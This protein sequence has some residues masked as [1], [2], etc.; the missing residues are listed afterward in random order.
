[1]ITAQVPWCQC[2][3]MCLRIPFFFLP[4]E[5]GATS[6][7]VYSKQT[8]CQRPFWVSR[9]VH[10]SS[11]GNPWGYSNHY[12]LIILFVKR[13]RA[14]QELLVESGDH[15]P[16]KIDDQ[17]RQSA[18]FSIAHYTQVYAWVTTGDT[19]SL[20]TPFISYFTSKVNAVHTY[21]QVKKKTLLWQDSCF[22]NTCT[23]GLCLR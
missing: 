22:Y 12:F 9:L 13:Q 20:T 3:L 18:P 21:R 1:M 6:W 15:E 10:D 7:Q 19:K 5:V 11:H 23:R 4:L 16:L 17:I 2:H 8:R 14:I